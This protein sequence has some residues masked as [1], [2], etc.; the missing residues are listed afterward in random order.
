VKPRLIITLWFLGAAVAARAA[1]AQ[2]PPT[3]AAPVNLAE[4]E[5]A[6]VELIART[7]PSVVAVAR[8]AA[9]QSPQAA[10]G[11]DDVFQPFRQ[12]TAAE[13]A[14]AIVGAGVIIDREGLVLTHYLAV[15][16]GDQHSVTTI[17]GNRYPAT[18][19]GADPR[20][21]L[22]ILKIGP[23]ASSL[24]RTGERAATPGSFPAI[25]FGDAA[26]ARKGQ[27]V[28]A[29]GNPYA[30]TS[31]GQPTAS[32]GIITNLARKAPAGTNFNDAPGPYNDHR[33]TIHHLGTLIQTDAKLG[34]SAGGGA[35]INLRGELIGLATTAA[36]IAGHEQPAGYAIPINKL[37]RR[38]IDT[39][40]EGREVEYGL[41]GIGFGPTFVQPP[42]QP[43]R[44]TIAQ[45]YAGGPAARAGLQ[46]GDIVNRVGDQ[47]VRDVDAVQL[48]VSAMP[49]AAATTIGYE[50]DG[51][52]ATAT[53][54]L[55]KL[56]VAGKK[57][58]VK[59]PESWRGIRVDYS[60]ALEAAPLAQAV[61][62][63]ALD[64]EGCV[65]VSEV[66]PQSI[67]WRVGVRPG[68]FISHVGGRR[69]ATPA[70]F[71]DAAAK[72]AGD[73]LDIRLTKPVDPN[74][75]DTN[76]REPESQ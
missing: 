22:A 29:I 13:T 56:A 16:E 31:D 9:P 5:R 54:T 67:A 33:T 68:M 8:S 62:S 12:N 30:I 34:W 43:V 25:R 28:V 60:T 46:S 36:T 18:I 63:G 1:L 57:I 76:R 41:L 52:A 17:D 15:R 44:L 35:L 71:Y 64:A 40:R 47:P 45:V 37:M 6:L 4:I 21:G 55:G 75:V 72:V 20:S 24:Q 73:L 53:V 10:G 65:L 58:V 70:E 42:P 50:R 74:N 48:A 19:R 23:A 27:F 66:E 11:L 39:L 61:A 26:L 14:A 32:W 51:R 69:V 38:V 59:R 2:P 49:P 7:E 3:P